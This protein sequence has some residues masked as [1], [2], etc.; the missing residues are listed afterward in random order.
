MTQFQGSSKVE[1]MISNILDNGF[2][3]TNR[4][5]AEF[6]LPK[7]LVGDS[8]SIPNLM[9]RCSNVTVPGRNISTIG[10]RIYG[11]TRQM[12]YE[13]LYNGEINLTYILSRDMGERGFFEK[14][15]NAVLNNQDYKVGF[16]DNYVG[17]LAIHVLDRSDQ[18]AYTSLV[19]EVY[20]KTVG[21]LSLAN[22]RENEY[23]TQEVTLCFRKYTSQ[24]FVRQFPENP[25]GDPS[26]QPFGGKISK[27]NG[28][29]LGIAS[30]FR[31]AREGAQG[32]F[33]GIGNIF[34][35]KS[36]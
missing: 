32:I 3:T 13:I 16:Y 8:A 24:F 9:I 27:N 12:P 33:S 23:L 36:S 5:V 17:A 29:G 26:Q 4:Y 11:P 35:P 15:M 2:L 1:N 7:A 31:G 14:W 22:D 34:T 19:E 28:D 30:F 10:Y 25:G 6:L 18:V 21:D 20:P